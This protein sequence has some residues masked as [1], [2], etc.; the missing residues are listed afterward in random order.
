MINFLKKNSL[1][2]SFALALASLSGSLFFSE[3]L[4]Y[5]PCVLCWW[6]RVF[7]YPLV[8]IF[9]VAIIK[10]DTKVYDYVLP[11]SILGTLTALYHY[12]LTMKI[13]PETLAPC[14]VGV[15]CLT[16]YIQWFGFINIPFLSLISFLLITLLML[17]LRKE[18][19]V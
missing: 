7:M 19:H 16:K 6:Q 18:N 11:L 4:K 12:L 17:L 2:L 3:I 1:Y 15:S 9:A 8:A 10:K 13:I 14:S 5:A